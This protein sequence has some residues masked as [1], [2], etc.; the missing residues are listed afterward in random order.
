MFFRR[1]VH[2]SIAVR[3][4]INTYA[5]G[6]YLPKQIPSR[7]IRSLFTRDH[8]FRSEIRVFSIVDCV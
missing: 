6:I 1:I 3:Y 7:K 2:T 5:D 4:Y 8:N